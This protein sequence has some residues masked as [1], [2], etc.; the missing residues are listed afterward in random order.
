MNASNWLC[1]MSEAKIGDNCQLRVARV[2]HIRT[3]YASAWYGCGMCC[4]ENSVRFYRYL[5]AIILLVAHNMRVMKIIDDNKFAIIDNK[6]C[7]WYAY[8]TGTQAYIKL[9]LFPLIPFVPI[10]LSFFCISLVHCVSFANE[11]T[12]QNKETTSYN[13]SLEYLYTFGG[14]RLWIT[15]NCWKSQQNYVKP[16]THSRNK[17][18]HR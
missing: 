16:K 11:P 7:I 1:L 4:S 6:D 5:I 13:L 10:K 15:E 2:W 18:I 9:F 17:W 8:V 12:E 14:C 3:F